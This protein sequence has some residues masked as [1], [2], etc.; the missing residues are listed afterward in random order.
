MRRRDEKVDAVMLGAMR[1]FSKSWVAVAL[2]GLLII[3]F[4]VWGVSDAFKRRPQTD[5]VARAG[6]ATIKAKDFKAEF[7]RAKKEQEQRA[8]RPISME[9]VAAAGFDQQVLNVMG[10]T[11]A[12]NQTAK[13][14]GLLVGKNLYE[15]VLREQPAYFD[16]ITGK[17]DR[18][19]FQALLAQNG[20]TPEEHRT[21]VSEEIAQQHLLRALGIGFEASRS[22]AAFQVAFA[23]QERDARYLI[24]DPSKVAKPATPT[25]AQLQAFL[26]EVSAQAMRPEMRQLTIV[27]FSSKAIAPTVQ[28]TPQEIQQVFD[29]R[30]DQLASAETRTVVQIT[31]NNAATAA[32]IATRLRNGEDPAAVAKSQNAQLV[33]YTD[34]PKTA[35]ADRKVADVAFSLP[36]GQTSGAIAGELGQAVVKVL[37]IKPGKTVTL[38]AVRPQIEAEARTRAAEAKISD[39]ADKFE[40]AVSGGAS[41]S[42]AAKAIGLT[43]IVTPPVTAQGQ[44]EQAAPVAGLSPKLLDTAFDLAQ[45]AESELVQDQQGE[46]FVVH[47]DRVLP[48][49]LPTVEEIRAPLTQ[50]YMA[51]ESQTRLKAL[52]DQ[53][54]DRVRKGETI[55]AVAASIG[56]RT[57]AVSSLNRMSAQRE[58]AT[59]GQGALGAIFGAKVNEVVVAPGPTGILVAKVTALRNGDPSLVARMTNQFRDQISQQLVGDYQSSVIHA[60]RNATDLK[61]FPDNAKRAIGIDPEA[62]PATKG[63]AG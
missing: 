26:K 39:M 33:T 3:A 55:E 12:L 43:P 54:A 62:A 11:L 1:K 17:F 13:R 6:S 51:R 61:L 50:A 22:H 30:K 44:A 36:A 47:V 32:A 63:K 31:A 49:A 20:V 59:L 14:L 8:Q 58:V 46:Y 7:E 2:I 42:E 57:G 5:V 34:R 19:T 52:A 23:M 45:G 56:A 15:K 28:V 9:E 10:E 16:P 4:G 18:K 21:N 60:T 38:D 41:V 40:A 29:F 48:P 53:V 25:D 24:L 37:A 35:I 27:R